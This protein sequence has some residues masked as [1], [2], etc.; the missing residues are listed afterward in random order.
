[1]NSNIDRII[2]LFIKKYTEMNIKGTIIHCPYWMNKLDS[3]NV[4]MRGFENGKGK[5]EVIRKELIRRIDELPAESKF[6]INAININ[7]F[8]KRERIGIDC[9]GL[10][11]RILE[12]LVRLTYRNCKINS[13]TDMYK[14]GINR[15]NAAA[16]TSDIYCEEVSD[17][18]NSRLGDFIKINGGKHVAMILDLNNGYIVYIHSHGRTKIQ[19]VHKE[20]IKIIDSTRS[21][22]YQK[23]QEKMRTGD[24]FG[25]MKFKS[26]LGDGIFRLK[27]F[28]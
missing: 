3:G 11:Y 28:Q 9:S 8:A 22:D 25:K 14:G 26:S 7:K 27:V 5:A 16:L 20:R 10:V 6:P 1:M 4:R 24:N 19:G 23:W 21:L 13:L 17:I 2:N 18:R 15:T 12:E